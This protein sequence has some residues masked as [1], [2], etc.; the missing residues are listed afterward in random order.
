[1]AS[2]TLDDVRTAAVELDGS[3]RRVSVS[4]LRAQLGRGSMTTLTKLWG[5]LR[6]EREAV[7]ADD[8][9]AEAPL[10]EPLIAQLSEVSRKSA[11]DM[12]RALAAPLQAAALA[13]REALVRERAEMRAEM[14]QVLADAGDAAARA[15]EL[16][17]ELKVA[18]GLAAKLD[19]RLAAAQIEIANAGERN[20]VERSR[21]REYRDD[22][23]QE[24]A[25][26]LA[27]L[28]KQIDELRANETDLRARAEGAETALEVVKA[29]MPYDM[30]PSKK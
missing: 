8:T 29:V 22:L 26:Q 30:T 3:G 28:S 24:H 19:A 23:R 27:I 10:P 4:T 16:A 25:A 1:M 18:E 12:Y 5:Q 11:E 15:E 13:Q 17:I 20:L 14:D 7:A 9:D 6:V 21:E 2:I